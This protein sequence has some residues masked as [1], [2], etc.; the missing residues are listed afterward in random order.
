ML[1]YNTEEGTFED[2]NTILNGYDI[3]AGTFGPDDKPYF[4]A[5]S[6]TDTLYKAVFRI[7]GYNDITEILTRMPY[8]SDFNDLAFKKRDTI[9]D[10][11][12][13]EVVGHDRMNPEANRVIILRDIFKFER[14]PAAAA[15]INGPFGV[16]RG[17]NGVQ[18]SVDP[19]ANATGYVESASGDFL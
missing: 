6:V 15:P 11:Y 9:F 12:L 17:E 16:C 13:T 14:L 18:F 3:W 19:V 1:R 4:I 2:W 7:N 8:D 5:R 10:L